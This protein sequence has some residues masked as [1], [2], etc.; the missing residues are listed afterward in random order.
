MDG[1]DQDDGAAALG[2][3]HLRRLLAAKEIAPGIYI[4]HAVKLLLGDFQRRGSQPQIG[5]VPHK[6]V[7]SSERLLHI[8]KHPA[9]ILHTFQIQAIALGL[10]AI[11]FGYLRSGSCRVTGSP[12]GDADMIALLGKT[13]GDGVAAVFCCAGYKYN[14][15]FQSHR[16][17]QQAV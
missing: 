4:H 13:P 12:A 2:D 14:R 15:S 16:P 5:A 10:N 3:H 8:R 11:G 9:D 17:F 6:Y 7:Q 1:A